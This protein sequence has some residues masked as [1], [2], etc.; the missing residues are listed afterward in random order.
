MSSSVTRESV[1]LR[2]RYVTHNQYMTCAQSAGLT[3]YH[4]GLDVA[5]TFPTCPVWMCN[6]AKCMD[7]NVHS[8]DAMA[9]VDII[10]M[11]SSGICEK[12]MRYASGI[13]D[14]L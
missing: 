8:R 13:P 9:L 2:G 11:L 12:A 10:L 5:F 7:I 3:F 6:W 1:L 14:A 4:P